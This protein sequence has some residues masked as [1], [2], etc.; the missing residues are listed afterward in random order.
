MRRSRSILKVRID[1]AVK[2]M[3]VT[4]YSKPGQHARIQRSR[5]RLLLQPQDVTVEC[6]RPFRAAGRHWHADMLHTL[7]V[8]AHRRFPSG[9]VLADT[10]DTI[11]LR[12]GEQPLCSNPRQQFILTSTSAL[13]RS[14]RTRSRCFQRPIPT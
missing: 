6:S 1:E 4:T 7:D 10:E 2:L 9:S 5:N 8:H 12:E 14:W 11:I 13:I 3:L